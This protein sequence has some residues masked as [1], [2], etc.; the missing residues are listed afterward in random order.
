MSNK[1]LS[2]LQLICRLFLFYILALSSACKNGSQPKEIAIVWKDG[3]AIGLSIPRELVNEIDRKTIA[4]RV[5]I[6]MSNQPGQQQIAG[7]FNFSNDSVVFIPVIP[8]T[9][10]LNY[11]IRKDGKIL[12]KFSVPVAATAPKLIAVYPSTDSLPENLLKIYL[13]FSK[14]MVEGHS[15][16]YVFL[17]DEKGDSLP[18]TFLDLNPELWNE[19]GTMLTIWFDPGRI[20]RELQPNRKLGPPMKKGGHYKLVV[21]AGWPDKEGRQLEETFTKTIFAVNR[22]SSSPN[23]EKWNLVIPQPG[24]NEA[25]EIDCGEAMDY[26][27]LQNCIHVADHIGK[28]LNGTISIS[29]DQRRWLFVPLH[30]WIAGEYS[31][32][33]ESRLE[34]LAGNNLVRPFDRDLDSKTSQPLTKNLFVRKFIIGAK[35]L[36]A[37]Q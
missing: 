27:L 19:D 7:D 14:P 28:T 35:E 23:P 17:Q 30:P 5:K 22:D 33:V 16:N 18:N 9:R 37:S 31:L 25:L 8:F 10:G 6:S 12:S 20:K 32:Q 26:V 24:T 36:H 3:K 15:L 4:D 29:T 13:S 11:E 34:D 1:K 21:S 2:S